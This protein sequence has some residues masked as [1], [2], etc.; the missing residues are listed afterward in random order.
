MIHVGNTPLRPIAL[1]F[2][3]ATRIVH[4]KLRIRRGAARSVIQQVAHHANCRL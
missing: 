1:R 3:G 2:D 4:L